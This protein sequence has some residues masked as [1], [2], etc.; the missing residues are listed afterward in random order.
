MISHII[1]SDDY[2]VC[3]YDSGLVQE[4]IVNCFVTHIKKLAAACLVGAL[5]AVGLFLSLL[6]S[7]VGKS[8]CVEL[9]F[10]IGSK[11]GRSKMIKVSPIQN[12]KGLDMSAVQQIKIFITPSNPL[13][14]I[15]Y[16]RMSK[17]GLLQSVLKFA[18]FFH[19][20]IRLITCVH[21][22]HWFRKI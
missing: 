1:W 20:T 7:E 21:V 3:E 4:T 10:I 5:H 6:S 17:I 8:T 22:S 18:C 14:S 11:R 19:S 13:V 15:V 12:A 9:T 16:G 2:Y